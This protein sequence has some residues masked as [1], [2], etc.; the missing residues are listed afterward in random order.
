MIKTYGGRR[1]GVTGTHRRAMMRNMATSLFLHEKLT[2]TIAKA[3]TLRPYAEKL[4]THAVHGKHFLVRRHVQDKKVFKKL[5]EILA[6]RYAKRPGGYT[7]IVRLL[8][9]SGDNASRGVI[10]LV[11]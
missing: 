9:R 8:P 6:P 10:T 4:I 5:F 1:L 7:R 3:K 11:T 2:T